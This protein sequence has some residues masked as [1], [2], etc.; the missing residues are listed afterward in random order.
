MAF[1]RKVQD[2]TGLMLCQ[3][4]RQ[5]FVIANI[6]LHKDMLRVVL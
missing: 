3:Q 6:A 4:G 1:C 2:G 5:Q